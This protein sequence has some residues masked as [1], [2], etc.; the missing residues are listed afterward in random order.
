MNKQEAAQ[1]LSDLAQAAREGTLK[2]TAQ[3]DYDYYRDRARELREIVQAPE[4]E[5]TGFKPATAYQWTLG[6]AWLS[7]TPP[8]A[9]RNARAIAV[10][11]REDCEVRSCGGGEGDSWYLYKPSTSPYGP[12][13]HSFSQAFARGLVRYLP[14]P[15]ETEL[16][17]IASELA[18]DDALEAER[19]SQY[20]ARLWGQ[21]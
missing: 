19:N 12:T 14:E 3:E 5:P 13:P 21:S 18:A 7:W 10:E 9:S 1:E 17:A 4:P 2:I 8:R 16:E 15:T 11:I 6:V 20:S